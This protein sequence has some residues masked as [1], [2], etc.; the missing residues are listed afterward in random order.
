VPV[1]QSAHSHCQWLRESSLL[2]SAVPGQCCGAIANNRRGGTLGM[3]SRNQDDISE[4]LA[5]RIARKKLHD[6]WFQTRLKAKSVHL[7]FDE[8]VKWVRA[9]E[10]W[11]SKEEWEDW[12]AMGE[13]KNA[14]IPS[15]PEKYY[16]ERGEWKGWDHWLGV[17]QKNDCCDDDGD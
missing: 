8:A 15:N 10:R 9:M 14:Y 16:G 5:I 4:E 6:R 7:P 2:Y 11:D 12:I 3:C 1:P 17:N 13:K